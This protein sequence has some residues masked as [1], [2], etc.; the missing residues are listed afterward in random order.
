MVS[1][2]ARADTALR[3]RKP[4]LSLDASGAAIHWLPP[5]DDADPKEKFDLGATPQAAQL[6]VRESR[7]GGAAASGTPTGLAPRAWYAANAI[8]GTEN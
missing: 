4:R 2:Q 5:P 3:S 6:V 7:M 8:A 1:T